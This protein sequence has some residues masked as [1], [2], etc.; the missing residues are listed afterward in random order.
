[1][2]KRRY[3]L[4]LAH[5]RRLHA[6]EHCFRGARGSRERCGAACRP[7]VAVPGGARD[8][9]RAAQSRGSQRRIRRTSTHDL[10]CGRYRGSRRETHFFQQRVPSADR[11]GLSA[12]Q[13]RRRP[14]R[15]RLLRPWQAA[16]ERL[17]RDQ[18]VEAGVPFFQPALQP[19]VHYVPVVDLADLVERVDGCRSTAKA[20]A[21]AD[22]AAA[23]AKHLRPEAVD[24]RTRRCSEAPA[25]CGAAG[26]CASRT[27]RSSGTRRSRR[28]CSSICTMPPITR[29][30]RSTLLPGRRSAAVDAADRVGDALVKDT[31]TRPAAGFA[32][33]VVLKKC[34]I[35][36]R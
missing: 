7:R 32:A 13:V 20:K 9:E 21:M 17:S 30:G 6:D 33:A 25:G 27:T 19:W 24:A 8:G 1:M 3:A 22:A 28:R 34:E 11:R 5:H 4:T 12:L 29:A 31:S 18:A 26:R 36:G 10:P 35:A 15:R 14:R 16:A 2:C 23:T